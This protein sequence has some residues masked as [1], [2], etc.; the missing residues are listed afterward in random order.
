MKF[1]EK[2]WNW[3]KKNPILTVLI[4]VGLAVLIFIIVSA[5]QM[6]MFK[7]DA[8]KIVEQATVVQSV[9][10]AP[11][12]QQPWLYTLPAWAQAAGD[13]A[14][15]SQAL[16]D[17]KKGTSE[18]TTAKTTFSSALAAIKSFVAMTPYTDSFAADFWRDNQALVAQGEA[19]KA[20]A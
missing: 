10:S 17:T 19:L 7:R 18:Y 14:L 9:A 12:Q 5:A 15:S 20:K 3:I 6:W 1:F 8:T 13:L 16:I 2:L 4:A 11:A